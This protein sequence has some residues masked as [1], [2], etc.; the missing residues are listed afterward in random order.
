MDNIKPYKFPNGNVIFVGK[1]IIFRPPKKINV[2]DIVMEHFEVPAEGDSVQKVDAR[3]EEIIKDFPFSKSRL[4]DL[5][6]AV[7]EAVNNAVNASRER[8]G[9][10]VGIDILYIPEEMLYVSVTDECGHIKIED[11]NLCVSDTFATDE[12]GRGFLIMASL[13]SVLAYN[14]DATSDFKEIILGLKPD[15]C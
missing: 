2:D 9:S 8:T 3:L 7:S 6:I 5:A 10:R 11:I 13:V 1:D 4:T 14:F 12:S 15:Q